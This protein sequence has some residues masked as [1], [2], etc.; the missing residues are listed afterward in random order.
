MPGYL[1]ISTGSQEAQASLNPVTWSRMTEVFLS[2][3]FDHQLLSVEVTR[4]ATS[5]YKLGTVVYL[6]LG[7]KF[8]AF[9]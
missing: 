3:P 2:G 4:Y 1:F 6:V 5:W 8:R 9:Y 7:I